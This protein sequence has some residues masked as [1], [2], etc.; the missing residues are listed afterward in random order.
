MGLP[1]A[2]VDSLAARVVE[3]QQLVANA[4]VVGLMQRQM[5]EASDKARVPA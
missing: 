3:L 2:R 1:P 5:T 4:A